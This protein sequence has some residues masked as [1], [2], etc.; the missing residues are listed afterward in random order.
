MRIL[1]TGGLGLIGGRLADFLTNRGHNVTLG[2]SQPPHTRRWCAHQK[3][4][5]MEWENSDSLESSC[6]G[7]DVIVHAAGMNSQDCALD[8]V[9]ALEFN[10]VATA[11]FVEAANKAGVKRFIYLS[12]AHV[13]ASPLTGR[14]SEETCPRN[15]HPYATSNLAGELVVLQAGLLGAIQ[16]T[17]LRLSNAFGAPIYGEVNCWALLVNDLCRQAVLTRKL[18][19]QTGGL[20]HRDFI[21]ISEVCRVIERFL[22]ISQSAELG[23]IYN[24]GVGESIS[25]ISMAQLIQQRCVSV[26]RFEPELICPQDRMCDQSDTSLVYSTEKLATIGIQVN[27]TDYSEEIDSLLRFCDVTFNAEGCS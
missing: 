25:V 26:L 7:V 15:I 13:Y 8:P 9:G 19:L 17:V 21:S 16:S 3:V 1:I 20:Q 22:P 27:S 12:S 5:Q 10:G 4:S 18:K 23:G 24:V 2:S 14:I 6:F 11:R